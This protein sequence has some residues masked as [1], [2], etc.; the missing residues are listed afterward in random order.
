MILRLAAVAA[1]SFGFAHATIIDFDDLPANTVLTNQ[2]AGE[3]VIFSATENGGSADLSVGDVF[4]SQHGGAPVAGNV[5]MNR[6]LGDQ[7]ADFVEMLFSTAVT[8]VSWDFIPFGGNG[9]NTT[10]EVFNSADAL[11]FNGTMGGPAVV[12][13]N[14]N[15]TAISGLTG[16]ARIVIGQPIDSWVWGLDNLTFDADA[17]VPVPAAALL[18]APAV[19]AL[20]KRKAKK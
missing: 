8:N 16:V 2:Y 13:G 12:T 11:I 20:R 3:G 15:Y 10:V 19:L 7:R 17:A 14:F 9:P 6:D 18:F 4:S 1:A 5:L